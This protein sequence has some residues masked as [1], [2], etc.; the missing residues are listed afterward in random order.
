MPS[1]FTSDSRGGTACKSHLKGMC[2]PSWHVTLQEHTKPPLY[3]G[4]KMEY[5][6]DTILKWKF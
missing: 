3:D 5:W 6:I 1:E 2:F 4:A